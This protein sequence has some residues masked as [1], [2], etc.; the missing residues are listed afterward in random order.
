MSKNWNCLHRTMTLVAV[1]AAVASVSPALGQVTKTYSVTH[2]ISLTPGGNILPTVAAFHYQHAYVADTSSSGNCQED[3]VAPPDSGAAI[4]Q[5]AAWQPYGRDELRRRATVR[6]FGPTG[7]A[8]DDT[9][10]AT[11]AIPATGLA[12]TPFTETTAPAAPPPPPP[13]FCDSIAT[14][15]ST[16]QVDPFTA[17]GT[18]TG[19]ISSTG[20]ATAAASAARQTRKAYAFSM[21]ALTAT[22]GRLL[23]N[24]NIRMNRTV[25]DQA[26]GS[27]QAMTAGIRD[28]IEYVVTDLVT[29]EVFEGTLHAVDLDVTTHEDAAGFVWETDLVDIL[30]GTDVALVIDQDNAL[31]SAPGYLELRTQGDVVT[32]SNDTGVYEG[33]LPAVGTPLPLTF[34]LASEVVFDY[35]LGEF[36]G[37]DLEVTLTFSENGEGDTPSDDPFVPAVS[38]W[39][40]LVLALL[41]LGAGTVVVRRR[42]G[43]PAPA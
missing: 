12:S 37:H 26:S 32:V 14:A 7:F 35:D 17:G 41:V 5:P 20:L 33:V 24:G 4:S 40:V 6:N 22:G 13:P 15:T 38:E 28:P 21:A 25:R 23:R 19:T 30:A 34:A 36:G 42:S 1:F 27:A 8:T 16:I 3:L 31:I 2:N 10:I 9:T 18:I 29:L 43:K 39:G 11:I